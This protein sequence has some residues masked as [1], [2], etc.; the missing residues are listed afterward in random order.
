MNAIKSVVLE[1]VLSGVIFLVLYLVTGAAMAQ[2]AIKESSGARLTRVYLGVGGSD[3]MVGINGNFILSNEWGCSVGFDNFGKQAEEM[4]YNYKPGLEII[5]ILSNET[6]DELRS[7][8]V[9]LMKEFPTS[10]KLIR[11]GV[12]AGPS[13]VHYRKAHFTPNTAEFN[14]G[15]NYNIAYTYNNG[16]GLSLRERPNCR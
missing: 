16:V 9:R 6:H 3:P 4:P 10:S 11:F 14:L 5:D 2:D 8:S 13:M 1:G 12:E 15:S 7:Y